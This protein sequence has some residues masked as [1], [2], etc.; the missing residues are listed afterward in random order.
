MSVRAARLHAYG[1]P[2]KVDAVE[3]PEPGE[4]E[5]LVELKFAGVNP[6]DSYVAR[7]WVAPDAPL[8]RTLGG[9]GA[10][11][12]DGRDVLVSGEGLGAGRD[13]VWAEAAVVPEACVVPLP[14][15][16]ELRDAAAM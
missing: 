8:P 11:T 12:V 7:G 15:G 5:V 6:I 2:L 10:G 3:L 13:G 4:G 9:E 14:D 1:E 16:V